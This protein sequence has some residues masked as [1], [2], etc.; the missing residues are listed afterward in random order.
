MNKLAFAATAA[1]LTGCIVTSVHPFYTSKDVVFEPA[2]LG[3]WTNTQQSDERWTFEKEAQNFYL[4][5]QVSGNETNLTQVHLFKFAG[6]MFMDL[7][8]VDQKCNAMP[9]PI[10][11]HLVLRV[12]Q[13]GPT[14]RMAP[15]NHDW[16][17]ALLE[18]EPKALQHELIGDKPDDSRVV[19]TADT[20]ELQRFLSNHLKTDDAWKDPLELKRN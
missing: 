18:K 3:Q 9:P 12:F 16:L 11:S 10:P 4:L 8:G 20:P 15:L 13:L 7:A 6:Q 5:T 14:L 17:K 19:L 1:L 2:L